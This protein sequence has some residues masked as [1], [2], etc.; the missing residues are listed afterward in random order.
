MVDHLTNSICIHIQQYSDILFFPYKLLLMDL[1]NCAVIYKFNQ[2]Y[3]ARII[4]FQIHYSRLLTENF[5]DSVYNLLIRTYASF[6][7]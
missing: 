7:Q 4:I 3:L 2:K 5:I 6:W 1:L